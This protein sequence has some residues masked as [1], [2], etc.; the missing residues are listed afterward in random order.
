MLSAE[1]LT[2]LPVILTYVLILGLFWLRFH[3]Q[4]SCFHLCL[5][6]G[7][8]VAQAIMI[9]ISLLVS[10][11]ARYTQW[12]WV[13]HEE[14]NIPATFAS[15]QL[16]W[17]GGC[18]LILAIYDRQRPGVLRWYWLLFG[19]LFLF[20][21]LDEF[22]ALH[23]SIPRWERTYALLGAAVVFFTLYVASQ[24]SQRERF[25]LFGMLAGLA[26]SVLGAFVLNLVPTQCEGFSF[27]RFRGCLQFYV[28]EEVLEFIG[29]WLVLV[30]VLATLARIST[31][32]TLRVRNLVMSFPGIW[33]LILIG[34]SLTPRLE[35]PLFATP[36]NVQYSEGVSLIGYRIV[37]STRSDASKITAVLYTTARQDAYWEK[38]FSLHLVD[39]AN[40]T[41]L[42][43]KNE[44]NDR[45]HS[46]WFLGA[47]YTPL[48][49]QRVVVRIPT[50]FP[51]N[52]A[53]WLI[54][55][56]WEKSGGEFMNLPILSSELQQLSETQ[57]VLREFV[58]REE[59][60]VAWPADALAYRFAN[61][62]V[63]RGAALPESARP[64]ERLAIAMSWEAAA[65]D[66]QDW[67]QFLHFVHE[68][69]GALWNHDQ[70]PLGARM[71]TRLW[72]EGLRDT[73]IWEVV[74]PAELAPGRYAV[75]TGLY[76]LS[77]LAR[78]PVQDS[79]GMMV[80]DA[81]ALLGHLT[82]AER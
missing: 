41:P 70:P 7:V 37:D 74:L 32:N 73:E 65:A 64:G 29:I 11:Q 52:R 20:L 18:A 60:V 49:R 59:S 57:I 13:L 38:G 12:L 77:D 36:T 26:I 16:A 6:F 45:Q 17:V 27:I 67:V 81:R 24:V 54:L 63:L 40:Q 5:A 55:A 33:L 53:F 80:A 9:S 68:E 47:Q 56:L 62:F 72:Y 44:W 22:I 10:H 75:Y 21:G 31:R 8:L 35:F 78:L 66:E 71:P 2:K 43:W 3:R 14:W 39:Q 46:L 4:L 58:I 76:R 51:S 42:A 30:S 25:C 79:A 1:A 50:D 69:S 23:E 61:G 82:I 48:Y 15:T 28:W 19:L 34:N